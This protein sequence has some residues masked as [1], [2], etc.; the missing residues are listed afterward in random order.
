M[1]EAVPGNFED[2]GKVLL[3]AAL[4]GLAAGAMALLFLGGLELVERACLQVLAG[5]KPLRA[6]GETLLEGT[7]TGAFRPWL[8]V[9]LPAI[10]ALGSGL[11]TQLVPE[12]RG[13]GGD[14]MIRAYHHEGGVVRRRVIWV[15]ALASILTLGFGGSGGREGPTMQIGG[16]LGSAVARA[17][18]VSP[19]E[20]RILLVAGVAAGISAVFKTPLGAA[21]L[22]VE[23]LYRDDFETDALVPAVLASVMAYS[24]VISVSGESILFAHAPRYPFVPAHLPLSALMALI[25]C[26]LANICRGALAKVKDWSER[27]PLPAW[28]RPALGGLALGLVITPALWL[29]GSHIDAPGQGLG[30]LGGG[31]GAAQVA[32]TGAAWLPGGWRGVE[33][34][35]LLCAGKLVASALTIGSGG[36]AGDFAP[37]LALGALLGGAFG[38]AA[39]LIAPAAGIDPG[40]FALVGMAAFYGGVAHVPL[41]ALVI[42]CELAGNY[43]L[44]VPL[45]LSVGVT[46][47]LLRNRYL[48]HAQVPSRRDSPAHREPAQGDVLAA[49]LVRDVMAAGRPYAR[50]EPGTPAIEMLRRM[51]ANQWQDTFPVLDQNG[52][53]LGIVASEV[54]RTLATPEGQDAAVI[55]SDAMQRPVTVRA[56]DDLRTASK[57]L[58]EHHLRELLVVDESGIIEGFL[59]EAEV[60]RAYLQATRNPGQSGI[61]KAQKEKTAKKAD[62]AEKPEEEAAE[63]Q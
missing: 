3:H 35:L 63:K 36:S 60:A 11:L 57:L 31:H 51:S 55:A 23:V 49:L 14:A 7:T 20:R 44:L 54:A 13:G 32:I 16:A 19:R 22:A 61:H 56:T 28:A 43:D 17:L 4:V 52:R 21:L 59:D 26:R 50:L 12:T 48:Y 42:V 33:L 8:L 45:M 2:L 6:H 25:I 18:S 27:L 46:F 30:I 62:G 38:R 10:G 15:K 41:A 58:L 1:A 53:L 29:V 47:L 9:F 34:L 40:A 37:S 39:Q 5:Y 24:V